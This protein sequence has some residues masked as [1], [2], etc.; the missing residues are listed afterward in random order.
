M[1]ETPLHV[2]QLIIMKKAH[3][4]FQPDSLKIFWENAKMHK[5]RKI[6]D[7]FQGLYENITLYANGLQVVT[8]ETTDLTEIQSLKKKIEPRYEV[9]KYVKITERSILEW[10][11]S[12]FKKVCHSI[13]LR[14]SC[15]SFNICF[16]NY[17]C[18]F[19]ILACSPN[20]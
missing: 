1:Q 9:W 16:L 6:F 2:Q 12:V 15:I 14:F 7:E 13:I 18:Y 4:K 11:K 10:E 5:L 8:K 20:I 3:R 17:E 19:N